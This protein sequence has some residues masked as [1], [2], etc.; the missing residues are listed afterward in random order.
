MKKHLLLFAITMV[1]LNVHAQQQP[2]NV[3]QNTADRLLGDNNRLS[4]GGYAEIDYNQ[5]IGNQQFHSG[6]LDVHRLIMMFGYKFTDNTKIITEIEFEHVSEVYIEQAFLQHRI[7]DFINLR[8]GLMLVP[9]GI[10]NEY[11]EPLLYNGVERPNV[12]KYIVPTTWRE[13]GAGITGRLDAANIKYQLYVMNGFNGYNGTAKFNGK[14]GLRGGRQKGAESFISSPTLSTKID[15]HGINN[16]SLG[17]AYYGGKSQS[18]LYKG[19]SKNNAAEV[20]MADSSVVGINMMGINAIYAVNGLEFRGQFIYTTI[21]NSAAYNAFGNTNMGSA[22]MGYYV[23]AGYNV[24]KYTRLKSQLIPFVRFE[25][26]NTNYHMAGDAP[27]N[28]AYA[29]TD[30]TVGLGWKITSGAV[31]KMDYQ[32]MSTADVNTGARQLINMGV[33]VWF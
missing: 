1:G 11:H 18:T 27:T 22:M 2:A 32:H 31:I 5:P 6:N 7:N 12:D 29:R 14:D 8:A 9:M 13:I 20:L 3:Q 4:I 23:E 16:L 10:V 24:F 33:G 25:Q 28:P 15:Y 21:S 17:L 30:I 19:I 26:Y